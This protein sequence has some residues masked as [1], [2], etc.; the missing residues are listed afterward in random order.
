M[1]E[2]EKKKS[3]GESDLT[4]ER[5]GNVKPFPD[6][7]A[8]P[9]G[10]AS[11][12]SAASNSPASSAVEGSTILGSASS[13]AA[14]NAAAAPVAAVKAPP[15]PRAKGGGWAFLFA[16]VS[17]TAAGVSLSAPSLRPI[18]A[19]KLKQQFGDHHWIGVLTGTAD[20]RPPTVIELDLKQFDNRLQALAN[21]LT[22]ANPGA[23][24]DGATLARFAD[25]AGATQR[26][27]EFEAALNQLKAG[28][29]D[30]LAAL[31]HAVGQVEATVAEMHQR[32]D[33][34]D[35]TATTLGEQLKASDA[36]T[37]KASALAEAA[38]TG[39]KELATSLG[40]AM[41]KLE[42][43]D[44][45][46]AELSGKLTELGVD[47]GRQ[48]TE[49]LKP[50]NER[51]DAG[52]KRAAEN[53]AAAAAALE[54]A[55]NE[56]AAVAGNFAGLAEELKA[57]QALGAAQDGRINA[58]GEE[59]QGLIGG[60]TGVAKRLETAEQAL[61][62][63]SGV[64]AAAVLGLGNRLR[65]AVDEGEPFAMEVKTLKILANGDSAFA[66]PLAALTPLAQHGVPSQA[67]LRREFNVLARK[68][69]EA[70]DALQPAWYA[71]QWSNVQYYLGWGGGATAG[72]GE[73]ARTVL[74]QA[75]NAI[76]AGQFAEAV[77]V[78]ASL[79]G[80]AGE[81]AQTWLTATRARVAADQAVRLVNAIALSRLGR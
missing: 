73:A 6:F 40:G 8:P 33:A 63:Q 49:A 41:R 16:L 23:P 21:T 70:E 71:R 20:T 72:N 76:N 22:A 39:A 12:A 17:L 7:I 58:V 5:G 61:A 36:Q 47:V 44:A 50:V 31:S 15:P 11:S 43:T 27:T 57:T 19:E 37:A 2:A 4:G 62:A 28:E 81:Q 35:R 24:I 25:A 74:S 55:R 75:A 67:Y 9:A 78:M 60:L 66:A 34:A 1:S 79:S 32:A 18:A 53:A 64:T 30:R 48:I 26:M 80:P 46:L 3:V 59:I 45:A 38:D 77:A 54:A 56:A 13:N 10:D 52:E 69:V 29:S 42:A 14:A 65:F 51:L 68:I